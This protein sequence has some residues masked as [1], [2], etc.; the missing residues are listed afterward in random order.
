MF[1]VTF[2]ACG[3]DSDDGSSASLNGD[4]SFE[5]ES[6]SAVDVLISRNYFDG[7]SID[8]QLVESEPFPEGGGTISGDL[9]DG[10]YEAYQLAASLQ[11]GVSADLTLRLISDGEVLGETSEANSDGI[12]VVQVGEF[13]DFG[14]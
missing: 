8:F 3:T 2:A 1:A 7:S 4:L 9:E 13:P 14:E 12:Y 5:V 11:G 10:D 6:S